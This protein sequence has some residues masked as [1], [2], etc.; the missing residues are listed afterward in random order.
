MTLN[1]DV[2][3]ARCGDIEAALVHEILCEHLGD[4]RAFAHAVARLVDPPME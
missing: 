2:V 4:L 1:P 3:R